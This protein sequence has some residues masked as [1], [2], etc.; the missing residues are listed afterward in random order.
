MTKIAAPFIERPLVPECKATL[1]TA[2]GTKRRR[3]DFDLLVKRKIVGLDRKLIFA[4][5][6]GL[7][8]DVCGVHAIAFIVLS[9]ADFPKS[10][11]F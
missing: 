11:P 7:Y 8:F 9:R 10:S 6:A 1:S 2:V 5:L 3:W 4:V